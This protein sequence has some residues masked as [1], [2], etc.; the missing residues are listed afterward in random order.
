M[1]IDRSLTGVFIP[2][3]RRPEEYESLLL[4]SPDLLTEGIRITVLVYRIID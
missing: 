4:L 3:A 1:V 2:A